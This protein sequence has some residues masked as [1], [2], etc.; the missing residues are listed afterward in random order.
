[1][2]KNREYQ[3]LDREII[4]EKIKTLKEKYLLYALIA[5]GIL[6]V[7]FIFLGK[8]SKNYIILGII[9]V[10][11]Y[12]FLSKPRAYDLYKAAKLIQLRHY[13]VTGEMLDISN[14]E[15]A[16]MPPNSGRLLVNFKNNAKVFEYFN[17]AILGVQTNELSNLKADF[18]KSRLV[19]VATKTQSLKEKLEE[20]AKKF[21][22]DPESLNL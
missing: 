15:G 2:E 19:E 13:K 1:M 12:L 7:I 18:E 6:L 11:L 21:G 20:G 9:I 8:I 22:I 10:L 14:L 17:N 5:G 3:G 16:E 4:M